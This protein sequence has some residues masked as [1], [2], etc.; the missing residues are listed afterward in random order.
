M[1]VELVSETF[2]NRVGEAFEA[3]TAG[4]GE[5]LELELSS[6]QETPHGF[7]EELREQIGRVPFSLLF[8][9][10]ERDR[11]WPQQTFTLRHPEL[12][13]FALFM[14]PLGP[15]DRGMQYEAVIS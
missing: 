14:V 5:T 10:A 7:P 6:C 1:A 12:G 15:D 8:H 11:Y 2:A 9:S 13:E 3:T 4:G